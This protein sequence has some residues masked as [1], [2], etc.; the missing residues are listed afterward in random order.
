MARGLTTS[1]VMDRLSVKDPDT[2]YALGKAQKIRGGRLGRQWRW[3]E[4]SVNDFL[5]GG[6]ASP[7]FASPRRASGVLKL[8]SVERIVRRRPAQNA[9]GR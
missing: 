6:H 7:V 1:E 4:E 2:I 3:D 5:R 9:H 8:P